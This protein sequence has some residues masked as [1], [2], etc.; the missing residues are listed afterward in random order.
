M[1]LVSTLNATPLAFHSIP[2]ERA[3]PGSL[4][5]VKVRVEERTEWYVIDTGCARALLHSVTLAKALGKEL[6]PEGRLEGVGGHINAYRADFDSVMVGGRIE[7]GGADSHVTEV[8]H[9]ES[10]KVDGEPADPQGL[11]GSPLLAKTRAVLDFAAGRILVPGAEVPKD[12]FRRA[13]ESQG[14][15]IVELHRTRYDYPYVEAEI[16][17][18]RF[19]FLLDTGANTNTIEPEVAESL[20]LELE[21]TG[22]EVKGSR[23]LAD[24]PT[25]R[26]ERLRIPGGV[27][28]GQVKCHV[29]DALGAAEGPEGMRLG[30]ILG[31][32]TLHSMKAKLDFGSYVLVL[33]K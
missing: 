8:N 17:G 13:M 20:G 32:Q 24:V 3:N 14:E 4:D 12:G 25:A 30:G 19:V 11:V 29:V 18:E 21:Q 16:E 23:T 2:M 28:L 22:R 1:G 26:L 15:R 5:L 9:L 6:R 7:V 10:L 31:S 27:I 33:P